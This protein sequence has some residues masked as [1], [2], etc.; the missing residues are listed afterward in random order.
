MLINFIALRVQIKCN[1]RLSV[2]L[3]VRFKLRPLYVELSYRGCIDCIDSET[4]KRLY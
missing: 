1:P 3:S 4:L 2:V